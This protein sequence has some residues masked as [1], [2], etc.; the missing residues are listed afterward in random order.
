MI[1]SLGIFTL[2]VYL[3]LASQMGGFSPGFSIYFL[4]FLALI[5]GSCAVLCLTAPRDVIDGAYRIIREPLS[6]PVQNLA[7]ELEE[8][9]LLV[10]RDGLLSLESKRRDLKRIKFYRFFEIKRLAVQ[11]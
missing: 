3:V 1:K 9:A 5:A 10:R 11:S 2:L 7:E 4:S 6:M 8:L